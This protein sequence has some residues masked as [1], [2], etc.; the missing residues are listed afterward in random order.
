MLTAARTLFVECGYSK[1]TMDAIAERA[2]VGVAT[3]HTYFT[4]KEGLFAELARMDMSELKQEGEELLTQ[5]PSDPIAAVHALLDIYVKVQHY[6]SFDV[7]QDFVSGSKKPGPMREVSLWINSWQS[8]L[9]VSAFEQGQAAGSI[10]KSL[11]PEE[12]S[13]II[14]DLLTRFFDRVV[15]GADSDSEYKKLK[16]RVELLFPDWRGL[17]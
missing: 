16:Q 11:P 7:V 5:L 9:L 3:V 15:S 13:W 4:T 8:D 1:T 12:L 6:I 10:S 14:I 17:V 2:G